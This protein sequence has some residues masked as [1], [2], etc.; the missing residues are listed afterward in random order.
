MVNEPAGGKPELLIIAA[1]ARFLAEAAVACGFRV[2]TIDGFADTEV[3]RLARRAV[4]VPSAR[5]GLVAAAVRGACVRLMRK[6]RFA[7]TVVG[8]GLDAHPALIEWLFSRTPVYGNAAGVFSL[9]RD[10][11]RFTER[12]RRLGIPHPPEGADA[13]TPALFKSAGASGGMHIR[14]RSESTGIYRQ[15]YLPGAVV[16]HLFLARRAAV[17]SIGWSTQW[18]SRHNDDRPFC[19][20]GAV[21]R[22]VLGSVLRAR[23]EDYAERLARDFSLVGVNNADYVVCGND[24]YLLELNPRPGATMQLHDNRQGDLFSAHL[25]ACDAS[26]SLS[27]PGSSPGALPGLFQVPGRCPPRAHAVLYAARPLAIPEGFDWPVEACD[28]PPGATCVAPGEPVCTL[29]ATAPTTTNVL[30]RLQASIRALN[31][32]LNAPPWIA[33]AAGN[34]AGNAAGEARV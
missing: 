29:T 17:A 16:S 31:A 21:N 1:S 2:S 14:F 8:P 5:D 33:R 11:R 25:G 7:G 18:Q 30:D 27:P 28:L 19:Y 26:S 15:S 13:P 22:T 32:R 20:G 3:S 10:R 6:R 12:L 23:A 9:C 34:F 24:L 4:R